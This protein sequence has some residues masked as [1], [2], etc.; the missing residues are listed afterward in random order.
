[1]PKLWDGWQ[2]TGG[3]IPGRGKKFSFVHTL[4]TGSKADS[5]SSSIG[6]R[7]SYVKGKAAGM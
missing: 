6:T 7:G 3:S 4:Q 5:A 1:V 2:R